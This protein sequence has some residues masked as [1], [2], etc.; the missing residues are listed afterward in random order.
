MKVLKSSWDSKQNKRLFKIIKISDATIDKLT[1]SCLIDWKELTHRIIPEEEV[2]EKYSKQIYWSYIHRNQD[3]LNN[4]DLLFK[5]VK[6]IRSNEIVINFLSILLLDDI[7]KIIK[8]KKNIIKSKTFWNDL[9]KHLEL[10][11]DFIIEYD[12]YFQEIK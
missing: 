12:K 3:F 6:Y 2:L 11:E 8:L 4:K 5:F 1:C 7:K 10:T 9:A